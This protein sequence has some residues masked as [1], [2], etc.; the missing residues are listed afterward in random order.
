MHGTDKKK[1]PENVTRPLSSL[2][3][4]FSLFSPYIIQCILVHV[5]HK[6]SIYINF[7][8]IST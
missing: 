3:S 5:A 2:Q 4:I 1:Q 6:P 7:I 8:I